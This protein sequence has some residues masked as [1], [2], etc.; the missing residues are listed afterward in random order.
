MV[1]EPDLVEI[2]L[3]DTLLGE[4]LLKAAGEDGFLHLAA[5]ALVV[6]EKDVLGHLLGDGRSALELAPLSQAEHVAGHGAD[7]PLEIQAAVL[8]EAVV[9]RRQERLHQF[10]GDLVVRNED[11]P[12][13]AEL[14][15]QRAVP[16]VDAGGGRRSVFGEV[17]G[18]GQ[19][20]EQPRGVDG[21]AA[22]RHGDEAEHAHACDGDPASG[23]F[24]GGMEP[25]QAPEL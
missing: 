24:H 16:G 11:A 18:V 8:E 9:L 3:E 23:G 19:I 17:G 5:E 10:R 7:Q 12:F 20:V 22:P 2:E 25:E 13:L 15:D 21:Q 1:P 14:A 6:G 4:R